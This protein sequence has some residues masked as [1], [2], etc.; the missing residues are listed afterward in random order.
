M[1]P[2]LF[3]GK[4]STEYESATTATELPLPAQFFRPIVD[5]VIARA[6]T[7]D[8]EH[9]TSARAKLMAELGGSFLR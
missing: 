2:D 9:V 4:F 3:V 6:E 7:K 8:A 5:F 1:R